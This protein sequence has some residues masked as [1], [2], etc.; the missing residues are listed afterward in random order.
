MTGKLKKASL[1]VD[2]LR[3]VTSSSL[4]SSVFTVQ[5]QEEEQRLIHEKQPQHLTIDLL[6]NNPYQPRV[7]MEEESLLQLAE[8]IKSQGFQGVLIARPHPEKP[9]TYQ[10]TAGHRRREAAKKAGLETLPVIVHPWS[11]LEMATLSATEN[12]QREDL[13]PLEE[14]KLFQL[15]IEQLGLTQVDVANA[16]K[17]DRGYV[18]NRLRLATAPEDI[19]TFITAKPDS[20]RAVIYLLDI[21]DPADRAPVI[22]QLLKRTMTTEDLPAYVEELRKKK[23]PSLVPF[24]EIAAQQ[25]VKESTPQQPATLPLEEIAAQ[26]TIRE[27]D[28]QPQTPKDQFEKPEALAREAHPSDMASVAS[29]SKSEAEV[30]PQTNRALS[31]A[32][33]RQVKLKTIL[34]YAN[35]YQKLVEEQ[36]ELSDDERDILKQIAVI[37]KALSWRG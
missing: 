34:R 12:I 18:R 28:S 21:E 25:T 11:D 33:I 35:E 37:V 5:V 6:Y 17:K 19:Q 20:I 7:S 29:S 4:A 24:V 10:I 8:T 14:G 9:G 22:E 2:Y 27:P 13:S 15:M 36:G 31:Q 23:H 32:R 1:D 26:Q 16:V 3:T 30:V